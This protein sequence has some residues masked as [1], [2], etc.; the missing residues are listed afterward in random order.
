MVGRPTGRREGDDAC[1]LAERTCRR[2]T[3]QPEVIDGA[4][5]HS[6]PRVFALVGLMWFAERHPLTYGLVLND[7]LM[8]GDRRV[9]RMLPGDVK[10]FAGLPH[11][12]VARRVRTRTCGKT[13]YLTLDSSPEVSWRD[14]GQNPLH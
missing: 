11:A 2:L 9:R 13:S 6:F 7:I 8:Y 4:A 14:K 5:R 12:H 1:R 3:A 10:T